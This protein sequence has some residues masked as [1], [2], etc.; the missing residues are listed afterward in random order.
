MQPEKGDAGKDNGWML[1]NVAC[2]NSGKLI[3]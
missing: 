1:K 2:F 3:N